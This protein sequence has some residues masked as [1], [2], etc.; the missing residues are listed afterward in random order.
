MIEHGQLLESRAVTHWS[1]TQSARGEP[2][3]SIQSCF[4]TSRFDT[5]SSSDIAQKFRSLQVYSLRANMYKHFEESANCILFFCSSFV[6]NIT[7]FALS[8]ENRILDEN[9]LRLGESF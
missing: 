1:Y 8:G 5:N 6:K 7:V 3:V 4:D 9:T 2:V